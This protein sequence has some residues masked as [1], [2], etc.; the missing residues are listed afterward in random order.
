MEGLP[1]FCIVEYD[2]AGPF[3]NSN[4]LEVWGL[5]PKYPLV[6][7]TNKNDPQAKVDTMAKVEYAGRQDGWLAGREAGWFRVHG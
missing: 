2:D 3:R 7:A 4:Y 6:L 5:G 1:R